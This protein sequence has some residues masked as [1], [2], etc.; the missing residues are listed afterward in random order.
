MFFE[1]KSFSFGKGFFYIAYRANALFNQQTKRR[2][3]NDATKHWTA[4]KVDYCQA[5][6]L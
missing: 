4:E 6:R 5:W 1:F 2:K 3:K